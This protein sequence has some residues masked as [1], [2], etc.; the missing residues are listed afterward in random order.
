M[1]RPDFIF[2]TS[3]EICN[4]I[5][6]I[7]TVLST[8]ATC[9][10]EQY[11]DKYLLIGPDVW[12]GTTENPDFLEDD[13]LFP[14]WKA[15]AL[16]EGLKLRTGRWNI[17]GTP[18]V[19]LV[20]FSYLLARKDEIFAKFWETYKLD[21]IHG[22]WDYVEPALFGYTA[23]QVIRS[24][25]KFYLEE[26][27]NIVAHFHEWMTGTG[28]LY[29]KARTPFI[30][31]VFT[32]H[33]TVLGRSIAG[34]GLPLYS[35]LEEYDPIYAARDFKVLS[36]HSLELTAA[37]E[38]DILT[39][40]SDITAKECRHFFGRDP[41]VI[42]T[43]GFEEE[44]V[45]K[46]KAFDKKRQKARLK[47]IETASTITGKTYSNDTL[48]VI[49][50]GR[51]EY[52]NKG[53]DLFIKALGVL[54]KAKDYKRDIIAFITIPADQRG[55]TDVFR[56]KEK[57]SN[58]LTHKLNHDE[59]DAILN[60]IMY[61]G[62]SNNVDESV[63]IIFVPAYLNGND[64]VI[65]LSYY[66]FLIGQDL[67]VFPSYYEP[68]GYTPLESIAF[69]IPTITT[70]VAG[71]GDWVNRS[72]KLKTPSVTVIKRT[73]SNDVDAIKQI[74]HVIKEYKGDSYVA[75]AR[76]ETVTVFQEALWKKFITRYFES[77][78]MAIEKSEKRKTSVPKIL[79]IS[80]RMV[81]AKITPDRPDWKKIIVE[82]PLAT[83]QHP[84]KE[85]AFNLWWSWN[86][87]AVELFESIAPERWRE[88]EYNPVRL[89]ESLSLDEVD[90]LAADS[91]FN[92]RIEKVYSQFQQYM[93]ESSNKPEEKIAYFSMEYGLHA[94]LQ[95]Y[96][97]GLGILAGDYLKQASDS[98]KNMVAVGLL[99]RQGYFKQTLSILGDQI[100]ENKPQKFTQLPLIPLRDKS[101]EW[102]KVKIAMPGR[103]VTAKAWKVNVGRIPLYL[104]DTDVS[105]NSMEDRAITNQLYGGNNEHRL[106]QEMILGLGGVRLID[107]VEEKPNI[108]HLNEGHSAFSSLERIRQLMDIEG[109]NFETAVEVVK[110]ATLFTTHTPVPAGHDSFEEHQMRAY[111]PHYSEH[112]KISWEE[113]IGLG[114]FNPTNQQ[115]KFSMSVLALKLAQQINGV[116]KI[117]GRV[118]QEM[119]QSLYPGYYTDE[120]NN[121]GYVTN[122]VHY[123]TWTDKVW[124]QLYNKT[125]GSEFVYNQPDA[126]KW[127][128]IYEVPDEVIWNNRLSLKKKLIEEIKRKQKHDL[129]LRF[130]HP[131]VMLNSLA[132]LDE[133]ALIFGFARRFATYKRAH[134]LFTNLD[135]L[136]AIVNNKDQPV[137][138][139][140]AGKAHPND[141]AGQDL[142]KRIIEISRMPEFI[143]KVIF[144][145]DYDMTGGK[146][147]TSC[148]DVWLNTPTRPLEASGTSGEK[149]VMNGV[150]N[151]SVLDGWWAEG[152][153][154]EA[155]WAIDEQRS[156]F[157]QQLQDELDAEIIM[158]TLEQEII[159]MYYDQ[160]STGIPHHW[161]KYIKNTIAKIAPHFTMQRM[162]NDYYSNFYSKLFETGN[163]MAADSYK[164]ARELVRWK[165]KIKQKWDNIS[166]ESLQVP[167]SNNG[168]IKFGEHF[169]SEIILSIPGLD[170]K[171]IGVEILMGNKTNGDVKNIDFKLEL[172]PVSFKNGKATYACSFPLKNSGVHDYSFRIFPKHPDLKYRMDFPMVKW[173]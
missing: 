132:N 13:T 81:E 125:F 57:R 30:S 147:M 55:P 86:T 68:W 60:E 120:I 163:R 21:S 113:F 35:R 100:S 67:S 6:G 144:L 11:N 9:I 136:S 26:T 119:F 78:D 151:F 148:V 111:M 153:L 37:R 40:V 126:T 27:D 51:Y 24:Y 73:E 43:N 97:G 142:I 141:K 29:I 105:E 53:L 2:E 124:Q 129:T 172:D 106:K 115:E 128:K 145:Q 34:S 150:M 15:N 109:F 10:L 56:G 159:P 70:L 84:L 96:S 94:S 22:A 52:R 116:S 135:R 36:K 64:G 41:E 112:F 169:S 25:S 83:S 165:H 1:R 134:L 33:A 28:V 47:A 104:L 164:N 117:H 42:T 63:H 139:L 107:Q 140:F 46:G 133:K 161:I 171:D 49:T 170:I 90:K 58:Y 75:A 69:K 8:K 152:Y 77:W 103:A 4:K 173:V 166:V 92:Q 65:D 14:E 122:G 80:T 74:A 99:Y 44:F 23:G 16:Q 127:E 95:I 143:G 38:A 114:R 89:L 101:G 66:D 31:T 167:D 76:E 91:A 130:E 149:A 79:K 88:F 59:H 87:E 50:S 98:N 85:M 7:Y 93:A 12:K 137:V 72:F 62:I 5:G 146:L 118:S 17:E 155:G 102:V 61:Q 39:T 154:P 48:L 19:V 110:S 162:L 131:K 45:P 158:N 82:P 108:Y 138:F 156:F 18:M 123:Y 54:N 160:D 3:W 32:T 121:I 71:F 157:N 20:D 168:F